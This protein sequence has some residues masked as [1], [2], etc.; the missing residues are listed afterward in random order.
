[1]TSCYSAET[2]RCFTSRNWF[3]QQLVLGCGMPSP[4]FWDLNLTRSQPT[5]TTGPGEGSAREMDAT[6]EWT[7]PAN[8]PKST[9]QRP[10]L[11]SD[12]HIP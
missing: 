10:I 11:A 3:V 4:R 1:M 12:G 5:N 7:R 6:G 9:R 8:K 2:P